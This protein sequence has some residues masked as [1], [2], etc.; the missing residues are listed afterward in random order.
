METMV[1]F[2]VFSDGSVALY[3]AGAR[4]DEGG[5]DADM[6]LV[7]N[8]SLLIDDLR[9]ALENSEVTPAGRWHQSGE[10]EVIDGVLRGRFY[11]VTN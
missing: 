2:E 8:T 3:V 1:D 5:V 9:Y 10:P 4:V 6:D 11:V 7:D